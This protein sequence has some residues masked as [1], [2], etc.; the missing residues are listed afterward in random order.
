MIWVAKQVLR[1]EVQGETVTSVVANAT[2]NTGDE[3]QLSIHPEDVYLF[4][5]NGQQQRF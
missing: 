5:V 2:V 3:V 4:D 1:L